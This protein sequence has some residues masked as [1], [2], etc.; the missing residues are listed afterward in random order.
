MTPINTAAWIKSE[1]AHPLTIDTAPY[2]Q[3]GPNE[4]IIRNHS[5]GL[6]L[7][8]YARQ[9]LGAALFPWTN[10]PTILG[11]D[12]AG[13]VVEVGPGPLSSRFKPGDRVL[14]LT[15]ELKSNRPSEGAFQTY[16]VLQA[17]MTSPIPSNLSYADAAGIPLG[18]STAACG[19]F[20]KDYL[21]LQ[22]PTAP[23]AA[24][25]SQTVLIWSGASSVGS[26]AIQLAVAAGY[27]VITT[28]SPKNYDFVKSLGASLVFDYKSETVVEDIIAAFQGKLSAGALA[29]GPDS[30][31]KCGEVVA[32]V[33]GRKF[34]TLVSPPTGPLPDGV[35][36]KFVFGSDLVENEVGSAV[37]VDFLPRALEQQSFVSAPKVEVV[38]VGLEEVQGALEILKKGVSA[39]KLV[40]EL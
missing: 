13:E 33:E 2:P 36:S 16:V 18:I 19:L 6:N 24:S 28:A 37:F 39:R 26:N 27:E 22:H 34:V 17:H 25:T 1:K 9:D 11:S 5:I 23:R 8:D 10:Y 21:A 20:Q 32:R 3:V 15:N 31:A 4:L 7:V 30:P 14:G 35:E 40:V 12:V 29:I 38:G